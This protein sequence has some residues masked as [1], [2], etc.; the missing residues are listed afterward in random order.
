MFQI[1]FLD[2]SRQSCY[3]GTAEKPKN[4]AADGGA[5]VR[6]GGRQHSNRAK[7]SPNGGQPIKQ[8]NR[9]EPNKHPNRG[10]PIEQP[11]GRGKPKSAIPPRLCGQLNKFKKQR[12]NRIDQRRRKNPLR[13]LIPMRIDINRKKRNIQH[14]T[15]HRNS[16]DLLLIV[17]NER[18][19]ILERKSRIEFDKIIN[20]KAEDRRD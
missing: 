13:R 20:D 18:Q 17:H 19:K 14:Q 8:P 11:I 12:D 7:S 1:N 10:Q 2:S 3:R 9:G 6:I 15:R 5:S 16:R 4:P